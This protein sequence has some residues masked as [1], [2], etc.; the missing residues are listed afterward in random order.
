MYMIQ[1]LTVY[2]CEVFYLVFIIDDTARRFAVPVCY[3]AELAQYNV[4]YGIES[5]E[6]VAVVGLYTSYSF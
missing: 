2:K 4:C 5:T 3:C 1:F 6:S